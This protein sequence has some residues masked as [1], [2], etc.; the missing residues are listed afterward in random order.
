MGQEE[1][2]KVFV[3]KW[4]E[5]IDQGKGT[6]WVADELRLDRRYVINHSKALKKGGVKL[7]SIR[8]LG[9]K[10]GGSHASE[11]NNLIK[12]ERIES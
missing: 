5:A 8:G 1:L 12:K 10:I 6:Q 11:L 4:L 7:P 9:Y 3:K 2:D